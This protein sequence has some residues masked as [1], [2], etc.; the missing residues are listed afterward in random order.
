MLFDKTEIFVVVDRSFIHTD[1][2]TPFLELLGMRSVS[3]DLISSRMESINIGGI[4]FLI[5]RMR[6]GQRFLR[7]S[8]LSFNSIF[9]YLSILNIYI[10]SFF[11][12]L[13]LH[14]PSFKVKKRMNIF[15]FK[16]T[17]SPIY[18][19]VTM[20]MF[21]NYYDSKNLFRFFSVTLIG[22]AIPDQSILSY[23]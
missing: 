8:F 5:I 16:I 15:N 1:R 21:L 4:V 20:Y 13:Y 23:E 19:T 14:Q 10:I 12:Y 3:F 2:K 6:I 17:S 11:F 22:F 18:S 9:T 7:F